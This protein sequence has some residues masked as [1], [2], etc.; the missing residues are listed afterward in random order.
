MGKRRKS[1][2]ERKRANSKWKILLVEDNESNQLVGRLFIEATGYSFDLAENGKQA[3]ALYEKNH[4]H[5]ILLDIGLPDLNG[6]EV[7]KL[8]RRREA[9]SYTH[10][11][12]IAL[13]AF[14]DSAADDCWEAGVDDFTVKPMLFED[15]DAVIQHWLPKDSAN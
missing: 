3:L 12:I 13:T 5:I 11:P 10:T 7:C 4:Y 14:G 2:N 8:I 1:P 6:I 15:L 9:E